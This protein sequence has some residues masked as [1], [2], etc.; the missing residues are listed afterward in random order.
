MLKLA[1]TLNIEEND[2]LM[3]MQVLLTY[4]MLLKMYVDGKWKRVELCDI[5]L[6]ILEE[7]E[8]S[9]LENV[10]MSDESHLKFTG[11]VKCHNF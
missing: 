4:V 6:H 9:V 5:F 10:V 8:S 2:F 7:E 11:Y 3:N 1:L